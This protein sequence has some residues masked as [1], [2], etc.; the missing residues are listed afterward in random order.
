MAAPTFLAF[1]KLGLMTLAAAVT[2]MR[3]GK[4]TASVD[5]LF[6]YCL[7]MAHCPTIN[8]ELI[9]R[10]IVWE[11]A[12]VGLIAIG[13]RFGVAV[14]RTV[15]LAVDGQ[16]RAPIVQVIAAVLSLAQWILRYFV[17]DRKCEALLTKL[18]GSTAMVDA[19]CAVM[20]GFAQPPLMVSSMSRFD[21]TARLLTALLMTTMTLHRC[22]FA[23]ACCGL[24]WGVAVDDVRKPIELPPALRIMPG[25][26]SGVV[27]L[28]RFSPE[29]VPYVLFALIAWLLQ[30]ASVGIL[31]GDIFCIPLAH[32]MA[33]S[34][35][36]GWIEIAVAIFCGTA[37]A[38]LPT[39][40]R[41]I[42]YLA[43]EP[44]ARKEEK[45][46]E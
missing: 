46:N 42:G 32:S 14:W 1:V 34:L 19:T 35:A 12:V 38:G 11:D 9:D 20:L 3:A 44:I 31:M 4:S 27:G 45:S 29:Y 40:M 22:L 8:A 13:A 6:I 17:L 10:F 43:E 41:T 7:R 24:L 37:A 15:T 21:P 23:V 26:S 36:S 2:W 5:A 16:L 18:G 25:A 39:L 30:T 33:R 28:E